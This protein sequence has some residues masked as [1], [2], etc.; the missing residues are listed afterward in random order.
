VIRL[1]ALAEENDPLGRA[2]DE[3]LWPERF[4]KEFWTD[5]RDNR[6][7]LVR[8]E[9]QIQGQCNPTPGEGKFFKK[10]W[11]KE[12]DL[13]ELPKQLRFYGASDHAYRANQSNDR[14][15]L[16][17]VG[18]DASD[19]IWVL[20]DTFWDR[21]D[22]LTLSER[23][24]D[25]FAKNKPRCWFA[26]KDAISGSIGPFLRKRMTERGVYQY[27]EETS[28][29]KDLQEHRAIS[30]RN[31]M[32]MGMVRWPRFAPWWS[33]AKTELITFPAGKHDDLVAACALL[34]MGLDKLLSA[35]GIQTAAGLP[36]TGTLAWVKQESQFTEK[37]QAAAKA[38]SG[39]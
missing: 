16:L 30:F 4:S 13:A 38:A 20:A 25:L 10:D 24:I 9:F 29:T 2:K 37:E 28:E 11:I 27:I 7:E 6:N 18:I 39:W 3:P 26:A 36:K 22:T 17:S 14:S 5:Q 8:E 33:E 21:V 1:P 35:E 23:M 31:R 32:A 19:T 15:C 34:G 12:Y